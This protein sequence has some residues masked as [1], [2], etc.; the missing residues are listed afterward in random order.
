[1]LSVEQDNC[2]TAQIALRPVGKRWYVAQT[3]ARREAYAMSQL[4]AQGFHAVMPLTT[5]ATR[6]ARKVTQ[7]TAALFPGY[8]FI[9]LDLARDRWRAV[10]G[11]IGVARL[12]MGEDR[13][14]PVPRGVVE[15]LIAC[16]DARGFFHAADIFKKGQ[17]V[18][19]ASGSFAQSLAEIVALDGKGRV[20]VLL[21]MMNTKIIAHVDSAQLE[22]A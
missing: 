17:T 15:T 6:H 13:P 22:P 21:E 4:K 19:V 14:Q 11:T 1:M 12:I 5:R 2:N 7:T 20:R 8:V 10:N 16:T 18:R 3:L 9:S